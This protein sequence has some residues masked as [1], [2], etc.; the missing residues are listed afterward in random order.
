MARTGD[1]SI[2]KVYLSADC[3][4]CP[5]R[6]VLYNL[7]DDPYQELEPIAEEEEIYKRVT[8]EVRQNLYI[9][10]S[11]PSQLADF[12]SV[13]PLPDLFPWTQISVYHDNVDVN[14][15]EDL[16]A[17]LEA[18][19]IFAAEPGSGDQER[20]LKAKRDELDPELSLFYYRDGGDG[21]YE[22]ADEL[23]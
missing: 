19:V 18:D 4:L 8:E 14:S 1:P 6:T 2:Y 21:T 7:T 15:A 23:F 20:E 11:V 17:F 22:A 16:S 10:P 5:G 3:Q 13:M 9:L 12:W